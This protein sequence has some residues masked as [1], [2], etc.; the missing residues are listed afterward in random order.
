MTTTWDFEKIY[1]NEETY[2]SDILKLEEQISHIASL[3]GS[4]KDAE[5]LLALLRY[6]D[7][8]EINLSKL[9]AYTSMK[10]DQNQKDGAGQTRYSQM[11]DI[12]SRYIQASSWISSEILSLGNE[13]LLRFAEQEDFKD[14]SYLLRRMVHN[15]EHIRSAAEE[16]IIANYSPVSNCFSN[17]YDMAAVADAVDGQVKLSTG[18]VATINHANFRS[19][20]ES[21]KKQDDRRLVFESMFKP[22]SDRRNTFAGI[23]NGLVQS[24]IAEMKNRGYSSILTSFLDGNAIPESVYLSLLDTVH[25][26]SP[27]VREY[28]EMKRRYFKLDTFHTYDRFLK[29]AESDKK[30]T[31]EEGKELFFTAVKSIGP[32]FEERARSVLA[33]GRVDVYHQDGKRTGAYSTGF[34]DLGPY[35]LLNYDNTLSDVFTVAHE[36]GHSIHTMLANENNAFQNSN[37]TIFVAEIASTF[38]EQV[39]L[40]HL[41]SQDLDRDTKINLLQSAADDLI[42]TFYRQALFADYEYRAHNLALSNQAITADAMEKIMTELYREY[43]GIDLDKEPYKND[44]WAYI[45]HLFHSPFYVYQYATC[46]ACSLAIYEKVKNKENHALDNYF[47]M[48][49]AG[50]SDFPMNIVKLGGV[51]LTTKEPFEAVF[52]RLKYLVEELKKL[53]A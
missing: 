37:Y 17:L 13:Q 19:Y 32:D 15:Q 52:T 7:E 4:L 3:Q 9:F 12:Y 51:D 11:M 50:G 36:A 18:E 46:F 42:S 30:Y 34:Y 49:K 6:S 26:Q 20:L 8:A 35:I 21:L 14:Y 44:V 38:N 25:E 43:Y 27:L 33:D 39:L 16:K 47:A 53:I 40:D 23:Y 1:P 10:Y 5:S 48:L 45:P 29:F 2:R 22:Y 41:M 24:N 28:Y 31:Y